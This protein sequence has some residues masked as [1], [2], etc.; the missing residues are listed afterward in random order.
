[1]ELVCFF[2]FLSSAACSFDGAE[3]LIWTIWAWYL[4]SLTD[5]SFVDLCPFLQPTGGR[6]VQQ[7]GDAITATRGQDSSQMCLVYFHQF[8]NTE[9]AVS[10]MTRAA[11][12]DRKSALLFQQPLHVT[13]SAVRTRVISSP[14]SCVRLLL[15]FF[16][17]SSADDLC[18]S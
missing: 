18:S 15:T 5:K 4:T 14:A 17:E 7:K 12:D 3:I 9:L 13:V 6:V 11:L 10:L 1:M 2:V 8:L 16:T